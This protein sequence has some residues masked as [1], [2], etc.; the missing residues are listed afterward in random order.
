MF[1]LHL[2]F[3]NPI[4]ADVQRVSLDKT[5]TAKVFHTSSTAKMRQNLAFVYILAIREGRFLY[6]SSPIKT[7]VVLV[8]TEGR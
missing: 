3:V 5:I 8:R 1:M 4:Q 2:E 7:M 6:S